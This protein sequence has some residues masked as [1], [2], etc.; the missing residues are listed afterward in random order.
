VPG[1]WMAKAADGGQREGRCCKWFCTRRVGRSTDALGE[2]VDGS[3]IRMQ[4][5]LWG[6]LP[7]L[8]IDPPTTSPRPQRPAA[9]RAQDR[10]GSPRRR[11]SGPYRSS[12]TAAS[13]PHVDVQFT[14]RHETLKG[15]AEKDQAAVVR[16]IESQLKHEAASKREPQAI[17]TQSRRGW[18][19]RTGSFS[20]L[21]RR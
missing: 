21:Q 11:S 12:T 5:V 8:G 7:V 10:D 1:I 16:A 4:H 17:T 14:P 13:H 15:A 2:R 6:A 19:L 20:V 18:E 9:I 3:P